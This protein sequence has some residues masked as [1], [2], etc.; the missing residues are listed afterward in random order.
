MG[1]YISSATVSSP[2]HEPAH[3]AK[4]Q[5]AAEFCTPSPPDWLISVLS[6]FSFDVYSQHSIDQISRTPRQLWNLL[7]KT[8]TTAIY[9]SD[10]LQNPFVR[11]ILVANSDIS[12]ETFLD[13]LVDS[14]S[15]LAALAHQALNS[16]QIVQN[17]GAVRRGRAKALLPG[18]M[19][20]RYVCA[21]IIAEITVFL[22]QMGRPVPSNRNSY[23]AAQELWTSWIPSKP[24]GDDPLTAWKRY[25]KAADDPRLQSI[26]KRVRRHLVLGSSHATALLEN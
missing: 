9:C 10:A 8:I 24:W 15:K 23:R 2:D 1:Y 20:A 13:G 7:A 21:A 22:T 11:G 18:V 12:S 14:Q 3:R 26:R 4:I 17:D 16:P 19:S 25:F 6:D 5:S